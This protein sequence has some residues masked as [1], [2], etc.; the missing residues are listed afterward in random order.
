MYSLT[1]KEASALANKFVEPLLGRLR[2]KVKETHPKNF[3]EVLKDELTALN[4]YNPGEIERRF[5]GPVTELLRNI[6]KRIL[7]LGADKKGSVEQVLEEL[8][9]SVGYIHGKPEHSSK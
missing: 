1:E 6:Y 7:E 9:G 5:N 2:N 4:E 8:Y 3:E